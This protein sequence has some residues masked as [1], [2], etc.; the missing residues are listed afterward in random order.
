MRVARCLYSSY[1]NELSFPF[2]LQVDNYSHLFGFVFGYLLSFMVLPYV[3]V[4]KFDRRRKIV[5]IL[6][7]AFC[8]VGEFF[9]RNAAQ[10]VET[11]WNRRGQFKD[12]TLSPCA[13]ECRGANDPFIVILLHVRCHHVMWSIPPFNQLF[14]CH[15][16]GCSR[17]FFC[18]SM[19]P[20]SMNA[21]DALTSIA[22]Q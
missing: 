14:S 4:G 3:A 15:F 21:R 10:W 2:L 7:C 17:R 16:Q 12:E 13:L 8:F 6:V 19:S 11:V 5:T 1:A 22:S 18:S 9:F 20:P